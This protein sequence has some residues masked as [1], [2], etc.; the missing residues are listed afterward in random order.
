MTRVLAAGCQPDFRPEHSTAK[1]FESLLRS[2]AATS[3]VERHMRAR[4]RF[5]AAYPNLRAWFRAPTGGVVVRRRCQ[6]VSVAIG[7]EMEVA[8]PG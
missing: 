1:A 4:E 5:V 3:T 7:D 2:F 8:L 6:V